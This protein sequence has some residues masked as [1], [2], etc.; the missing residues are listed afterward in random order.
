MAMTAQEQ[1]IEKSNSQ[2]DNTDTRCNWH[3]PN[4][5]KEDEWYFGR[6]YGTSWEPCTRVG[7]NW[8]SSRG[9]NYSKPL[10]IVGPIPRGKGFVDFEDLKG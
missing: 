7:D 10:E 1:R 5:A 2:S 4:N 8:Y 6:W 3:H 9:E